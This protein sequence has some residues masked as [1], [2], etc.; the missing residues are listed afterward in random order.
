MT[1]HLRRFENK[2]T[3]AVKDVF[4]RSWKELCKRLEL[5]TTKLPAETWVIPASWV[6]VENDKVVG[7][8]YLRGEL[9]DRLYVDPALQ[10]SG[11]GTLLLNKALEEGARLLWVDEENIWGRAF[12]EKNGWSW[13]GID[14]PG[15]KFPTAPMLEYEYKG[16][17]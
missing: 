7:F 11:V 3:L 4:L 12:Y 15:S 5:D 1:I 14:A 6:A 17:P 10:R 8:I 9:V 13:T 2:D 16:A